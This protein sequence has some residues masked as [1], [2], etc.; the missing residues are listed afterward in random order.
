VQ[1]GY[2]LDLF[3][4]A[5]NSAKEIRSD[6]GKLLASHEKVFLA[7]ATTMRRGT[8]MEEFHLQTYRGLVKKLRR[9][10]KR[11]TDS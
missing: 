1:V 6:E 7:C 3:D 10:L 9:L 4:S 11:K 5:E 2:A 8:P